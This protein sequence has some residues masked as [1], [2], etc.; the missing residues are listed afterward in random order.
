M[1]ETTNVTVDASKVE[2]VTV[3]RG[4]Q[5]RT[6]QGEIAEEKDKSGKVTKAAIKYNY[7]RIVFPWSRS[8]KDVDDKVVDG[9]VPTMA[10]IVA[11]I[12]KNEM[13]TEIVLDKN[14]NMEAPCLVSFLVEGINKHLSQTARAKAENTPES[15][16]EAAISLFMKKTGM[17]R[18]D[19]ESFLAATFGA[20]Q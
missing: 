2:K 9:A 20:A 11:W 14:N 13:T 7:D 8:G 15:A 12:H 4:L 18:K 3:N 10:E 17:S 19:A 1:S 6:F 5:I 16:K